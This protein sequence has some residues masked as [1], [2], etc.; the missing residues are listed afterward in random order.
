MSVTS[1][2]YAAVLAASLSPHPR[3][4]AWG[5]TEGDPKKKFAARLTIYDLPPCNLCGPM[6]SN[7]PCGSA[8]ALPPPSLGVSSLDLGRWSASGL[9]FDSGL[10][11]PILPALGPGGATT[12]LRNT[13]SGCR[14]L[15][16]ELCAARWHLLRRGNALL[17]LPVVGVSSLDLGHWQCW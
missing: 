8:F 11:P 9:F 4:H 16:I 10:F 3:S 1:A 15:A 7:H 14:H 2:S 12:A 17:P 5:G 13:H 6:P